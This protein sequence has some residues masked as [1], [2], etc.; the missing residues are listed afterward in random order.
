MSRS[1]ELPK[2]IQI[3]CLD[4]ENDSRA[5]SKW[6]RDTYGDIFKQ[7]ATL[8]EVVQVHEQEFEQHPSSSN[9]ERLQKVQ[10]ELI[11]FYAV[12]EKFWKQKA[13]MQWFTDGDRNTKFFHAHVNGKRRRLQLKRIQDHRGVWLDNEEEIAQEAIRFYTE[14]FREENMP[15][16]FKI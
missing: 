12:E 8:E 13:G 4:E 1:W 11:K 14:Q 7:I 10:A 15:T 3:N 9:R 2:R 6:S 16:D 5:L